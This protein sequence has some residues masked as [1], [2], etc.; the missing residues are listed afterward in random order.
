MISRRSFAACAALVVW[1]S[2]NCS[3]FFQPGHVALNTRVPPALHAKRGD[4]G[5]G[6]EARAAARAAAKAAA[7]AGGAT[8]PASATPSSQAQQGGSPT[9]SP[10][11][12]STATVTSPPTLDATNANENQNV[13]IVDHLNLNHE[14]GRHDLLKA[15]YFDLL[16]LGVDPRKEDNIAKGKKTLWANGACSKCATQD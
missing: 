1:F 12:Y 8:P 6:A 4:K 3:A 13:L 9:L 5:Y 7:R 11:N 15:F 10:P 2:T 14:K 16:G